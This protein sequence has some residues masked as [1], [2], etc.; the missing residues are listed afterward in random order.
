M[1]KYFAALLVAVFALAQPG[2]CFLWGM[3]GGKNKKSNKKKTKNDAPKKIAR[4]LR[5]TGVTK[6]LTLGEKPEDKQYIYLSGFSLVPTKRC[7]GFLYKKKGTKGISDSERA[8]IA[9]TLASKD[10]QFG[11]DLTQ[12]FL[13]YVY[14]TKMEKGKLCFPSA[15]R[16][17]PVMIGDL[18]KVGCS[19]MKFF[20]VTTPED[21]G[22]LQ[23]SF[24]NIKLAEIKKY[25]MERFKSCVR[26]NSYDGET[27]ED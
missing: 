13:N 27:I 26:N 25:A 16:T 21:L 14:D 20:G 6:C 2:H 18:F 4:E 7:N 5:K 19:R 22:N 8:K 23:D 15:R 24:D 11:D 3:F 9:L 17:K 10:K 12:N 1:K